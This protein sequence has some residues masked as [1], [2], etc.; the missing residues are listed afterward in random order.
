MHKHTYATSHCTAMHCAVLRK[1][2][3]LLHYIPY[4]I[5]K[6]SLAMPNADP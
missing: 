2:L 1:T 4:T 3:T 5:A 6:I